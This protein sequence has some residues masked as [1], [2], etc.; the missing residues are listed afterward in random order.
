MRKCLYFAIPIAIFFTGCTLILST[1][2][3]VP[4]RPSTEITDFPVELTSSINTQIEDAWQD[5]YAKFLRGIDTYGYTTRDYIIPGSYEIPPLFYIYDIDQNG[6]PELILICDNG[7]WEDLSC[8]VFTYKN[9]AAQKIGSMKFNLFGA[10]GAPNNITEGLFSEDTYKGDF[11]SLHYYTIKN[12]VFIEQLFCEFDSRTISGNEAGNDEY[13]PF[14]FY[15]ITEENIKESIY[16]NHMEINDNIYF[17]SKNNTVVEYEGY[18]VPLSGNG[19]RQKVKL[20]INMLEKIDDGNLYLL[21]LDALEV[22]DPLDQIPTRHQTLGCFYVTSDKIYHSVLPFDKVYS[23]EENQNIVNGLKN[24]IYTSLSSWDIVCIENGTNDI[25]DKNNYHKYVEVDENKRIFHLYNDYVG[26]TRGYKKIIWEKNKGITYYKSGSGSML[27]H[28]ELECYEVNPNETKNS[29]YN[30]Y[31]LESELYEQVNDSLNVKI[32]YPQIINNKNLLVEKCNRLLKQAALN[33]YYEKWLLD[34]L[35]LEQ[36]YSIE[37][38]DSELLSIV[39]HGYAYVSE[40][41]H[42]ADTYHAVTIDIETVEQLALSDFVLYEDLE[43]M[44]ADGKYEVLYGGMKMLTT[45]EILSLV[46][47]NFENTSIENNIH[48]FYITDEG[49]ICIIIDLPKTGGDYSILCI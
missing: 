21:R 47:I 42:L 30:E 20:N 35:N 26:G 49:K 34:G 46:R 48:K 5:V 39:F 3:Q 38:Q 37:K 31:M 19:V 28:I 4:V 15:Q 17:F 12:D 45:E 32:S 40:T 8:D 24:D 14:D 11:G 18:I 16:S 7:N 29:T 23:D 36:S 9:N 2:E 10:I 25:P 27:M 33:K 41:A 13:T 1:T 6:T 43:K 22:N 44:I